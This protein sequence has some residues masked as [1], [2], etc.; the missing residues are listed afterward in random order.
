MSSK[1]TEYFNG[2]KKGKYGL[3]ELKL[4]LVQNVKSPKNYL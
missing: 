4:V 2:N 3:Q 1:R